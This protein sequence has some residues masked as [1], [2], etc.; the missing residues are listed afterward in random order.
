VIKKVKKIKHISLKALRK[1]AWELQSRYI[2]QAA[3][4]DHGI[5]LC[6][7]CGSPHY[8]KDMELGHYIHKD[9]LDYDLVNLHPQCN[10]CNRRMHGN[11]ALYAERLI[12]EYGEQTIAELRVRSEQI[13]KFTIFELEELITKYKTLLTELLEGR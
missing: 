2:R 13:K 5:V 9:C 11:G 7:T 3:A 12:A 10:Y 1:K 4:D 6:Y 8:W